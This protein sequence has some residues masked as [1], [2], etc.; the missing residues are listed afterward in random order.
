M[1][2]FS[3]SAGLHRPQHGWVCRFWFHCALLS[4]G[5]IRHQEHTAG[6]LHTEGKHPWL[7]HHKQ[8]KTHL[9]CYELYMYLE[10]R[11]NVN[12]C[13]NLTLFNK[14]LASD[15]F[16]LEIKFCISVGEQLRNT[17]AP[18][19]AQNRSLSGERAKKVTSRFVI[20]LLWNTVAKQNHT[21]VHISGPVL[22]APA[23]Y[24]RCVWCS[25]TSGKRSSVGTRASLSQQ[26]EPISLRLIKATVY[27]RHV[28][29][30]MFYLSFFSPCFLKV[31][32]GMTL[33]S[34]DPC[35]KT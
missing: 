1:S 19:R 3:T 31:I 26:W 9:T 25:D 13:S 34:G 30:K 5:G 16:Y 17:R 23:V 12:S 35:F 15:R 20:K 33:L 11:L 32:I 21:P 2:N 10:F 6:Q 18:P 27:E 8:E 29:F 22:P 28:E 24:Y 7:F 4:V 14:A